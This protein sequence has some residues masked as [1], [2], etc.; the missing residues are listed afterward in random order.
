MTPFERLLLI[1]RLQHEDHD[2]PTYL[3]DEVKT[4]L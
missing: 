2:F 4:W 1:A 3:L